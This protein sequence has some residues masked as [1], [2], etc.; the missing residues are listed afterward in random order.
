MTFLLKNAKLAA[1]LLALV[2]AI[3]Y[4][5]TMAAYPTNDR[6]WL[7]NSPDATAIKIMAE[8]FAVNHNFIWNNFSTWPVDIFNLRS[9]N[10]TNQGATPGTFIGL[11]LFYGMC[12]LIFGKLTVFI[13]AILAA[14]GVWLMFIL[15]KYLFDERV[16]LLAEFLVIINPAY[17]YNAAQPYGW[18]I[19][20]LICVLGSLLLLTKV[21][22]NILSLLISGVFFSLAAAI[23]TSEIIWLIP[24]FI[25][26]MWLTK[27]S[28]RKIIIWFVGFI[29]LGK[30]I[31]YIE[32]LLV[33]PQAIWAYNPKILQQANSP[34]SINLV[35][36]AKNIWWYFLQWQWWITIPTLVGIYF[37]LKNHTFK[38]QLYLWGLLILIIGQLF[39]YGSW[40]VMDSPG[41]IEPTIG[42]SHIRYWLPIFFGLVPVLALLINKLFENKKMSLLG[43]GLMVIYVIGALILVLT[44]NND[45][46][47]NI[48]KTLAANANIR[49]EI[50]SVTTP[51]TLIIAERAD[52]FLIDARPVTYT[53]NDLIWPIIANQL[54]NGRQA[55]W[56]GD[57]NILSDT[58]KQNGIV[59]QRQVLPSGQVITWLMAL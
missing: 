29:L 7:L 43:G 3:L 46:L 14:L 17:W 20:F 26:V 55:M 13:N 59:T 11:P 19:P 48:K 2:A 49:Q 10:V 15:V 42:N 54:R 33:T 56:Y 57:M 6:V 9:L 41:I 16:A 39:I 37:W 22:Y 47:L 36:L 21:K 32:N 38:Q 18:T 4:I 5:V 50:L 27:Q 28:W 58:A 44:A 25:L 51:D 1:V 45:S 34:F 24:L 30:I 12:Q 23:R 40:I 31:I 52:K 35:S 8:N 53:V